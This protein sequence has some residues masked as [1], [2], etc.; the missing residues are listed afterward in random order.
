MSKRLV[1]AWG[2]IAAGLA[3]PALAD[4]ALF[5]AQAALAAEDLDHRRGGTSEAEQLNLTSQQA[6]NSGNNASMGSG[7]VKNTG[8][9]HQAQ[10]SGNSGITAVMQNTGDLVNFT[11]ATSVNVYMR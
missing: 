7:A 10:V 9:I 4:E 5:G 11:N 8:T 6:T 3:Q 1:L 2:L